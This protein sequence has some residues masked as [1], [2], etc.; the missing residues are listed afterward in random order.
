MHRSTYY[1][2]IE[3]K[4]EVVEDYDN[5]VLKINTLTSLIILPPKLTMNDGSLL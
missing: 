1:Y 3:H 5:D 4:H 2:K